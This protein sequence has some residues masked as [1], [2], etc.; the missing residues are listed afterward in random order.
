MKKEEL[1]N[2]HNAL[3]AMQTIKEA[4][5]EFKSFV[6]KF[7]KHLIRETD[8]VDILDE[9]ELMDECI[10]ETGVKY[11]AK[12][13]DSKAI[14]ETLPNGNKMMT[15]LLLGENPEYD[16]LKKEYKNNRNDILKGCVEIPEFEN[17]IKKN[18]LP[19]D[20]SAQLQEFIEDYID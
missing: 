17:K 18:D 1:I 14:Y 10:R 2:T 19:K 20:L 13:K 8:I 3:C 4:K 5:Y 16:K 12:D 15:G 6:N 7:K 11:C 9:I